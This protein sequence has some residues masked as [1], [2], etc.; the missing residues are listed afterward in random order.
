MTTNDIHAQHLLS[1][2]EAGLRETIRGLGERQADALG[3]LLNKYPHMLR[4]LSDAK[5]EFIAGLALVALSRL[6]AGA[7]GEGVE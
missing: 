3:R 2:A 5:L 6:M 7:F 4:A 1:Q